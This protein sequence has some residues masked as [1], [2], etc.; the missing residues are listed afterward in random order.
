MSVEKKSEELDNNQQEEEQKLEGGSYEVLKNR[1]HG[2]NVELQ[3]KLEQLNFSRQE[4]FGTTDLS[5]IGSERVETE[6]NC[7]PRDVVGLGD[8]LLFGYN[9]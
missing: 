5:I 4:I 2:L 9:F 6:N 7:I 8:H 1:L 3:G